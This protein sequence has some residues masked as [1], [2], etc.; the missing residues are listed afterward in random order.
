MAHENE[1]REAETGT[2]AVEM[3]KAPP[4]S[5][6]C[7]TWDAL[8]ISGDLP[9]FFSP[10]EESKRSGVRVKFLTD[11]P[12]RETQ[13]RFNPG[14][15]ELW[16]DIEHEGEVKT[17]TIS[18]I[19]LLVELKKHE[20]LTGKTFDIQLV[21][22]DDAF[23]KQRPKYKGKDRYEVTLVER[24]GASSASGASTPGLASSPVMEEEVHDDR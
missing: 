12:K 9:D 23:R 17:W 22:V 3:N 11:G 13:N 7:P 4:A 14:T 19:S 8:G 21:P 5:P 20:P 2:D 16:F 10:G 6:S 18:Q 24:Q 15:P 1:T